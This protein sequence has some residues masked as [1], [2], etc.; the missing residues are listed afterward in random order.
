MGA[1]ESSMEMLT[2]TGEPPW[3][4]QGEAMRIGRE[5]ELDGGHR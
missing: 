4:M 5:R 3:E 2:R 1:T